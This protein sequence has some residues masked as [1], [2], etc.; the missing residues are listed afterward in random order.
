MD[1]QYRHEKKY[2]IAYA[3]K[4]LLLCRLRAALQVDPHALPQGYYNVRTLYLDDV[5]DSA[6]QDTVT[7]APEKVKYRIRMYNGDTSYI[8][9]E[10]K[11]KRYGGG[12]KVGALLSADECRKILAGDCAFLR[13][14]DSAFLR[15]CYAV[16]VAGGLRPKLIVQYDRHAFICPQD[17]VRITVDEDIRVCRIPDAFFDPQPFGTSVMPNRECILEIKYTHFLPD[18]VPL[19]VG[20]QNRPLTAMSKFSAGRL[21]Y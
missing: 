1:V 2:R 19:L 3:E 11:V 18:Y 17:D 20:I 8:R 6:M 12:Y 21:Y 7:G 9:L 10:K 4:E 15:A 5:N 14:H 13:T 16:S